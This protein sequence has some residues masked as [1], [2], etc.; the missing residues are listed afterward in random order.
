M[1]DLSILDACRDFTIKLILL[2]R[3]PLSGP[4]DDVV[5]GGAISSGTGDWFPNEPEMVLEAALRPVFMNCF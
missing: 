4:A 5:D 3:R 2:S 1:P